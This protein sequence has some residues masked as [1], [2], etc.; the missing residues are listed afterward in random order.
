MHYI[1]EMTLIDNMCQEKDEEN[2]PALKTALTL[3]YND[4]KTTEKSME[5]D[6]LQ[7]PEIALATWGPTEQQ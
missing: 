1:P 2:L 6:W 5:K 4:M 7:P 3:Q